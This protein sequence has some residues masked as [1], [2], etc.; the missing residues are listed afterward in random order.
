MRLTLDI[1]NGPPSVAQIRQAR[2]AILRQLAM[3]ALVFPVSIA[4][5]ALSST[6]CTA[7]A[8]VALLVGSVMYLLYLTNDGQWLLFNYI[9]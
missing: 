8:Y 1:L 6:M 9:T 7:S 2:A 5:I 4:G 3:V